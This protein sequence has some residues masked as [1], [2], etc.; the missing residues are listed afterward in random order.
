MDGQ[1]RVGTLSVHEPDKRPADALVLG[2]DHP[3]L[4]ENRPLGKAVILVVAL[5]HVGNGFLLRQFRAAP[6][7]VTLDGAPTRGVV[8]VG[9]GE[10]QNEP[11]RQ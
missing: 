3:F 11:S 2:I 5:G 1:R 4:V 9:T 10:S 7:D 8:C 6:D